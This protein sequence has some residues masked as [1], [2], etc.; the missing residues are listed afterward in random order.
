MLGLF[1]GLSEPFSLSL[2]NRNRFESS[3]FGYRATTMSF[4]SLL[5]N[6]I[7]GLIVDN[8]QWFSLFNV[9]L[10]GLLLSILILFS[11]TESY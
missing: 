8:L 4:I 11:E 3:F 1:C 2:I 9:Y 10:I 5:F 7:G 6:L